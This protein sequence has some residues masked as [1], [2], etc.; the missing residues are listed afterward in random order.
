MLNA[1]YGEG[2]WQVVMVYFPFHSRSTLRLHMVQLLEEDSVLRVDM[3]KTAQARL[4]SE[5]DCLY[6][7]GEQLGEN[8][9]HV[10]AYYEAPG[11]VLKAK[12]LV[13]TVWVAVEALDR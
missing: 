9:A 8:L 10:D 11:D 12:L 13:A 6:S 5:D 4:L 2:C 7:P 1:V 3:L